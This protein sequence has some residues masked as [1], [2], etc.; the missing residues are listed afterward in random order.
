[1]QDVSIKANGSRRTTVPSVFSEQVCT[2]IQ[3]W[4]TGILVRVLS[5]VI[6]HRSRRSSLLHV[7]LFHMYMHV[8]VAGGG[9]LLDGL[10]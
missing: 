4:S 10:R 3:S 5:I 1:M 8:A 6:V 9:S 7:H 2:Y